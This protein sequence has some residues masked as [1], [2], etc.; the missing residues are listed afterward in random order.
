MLHNTCKILHTGN[1]DKMKSHPATKQ[2]TI[3]IAFNTDGILPF[4]SSSLTVWPLFVSLLNLP[5]RIRAYKQNIVTFILW[6]GK[7]KPSMTLLLN[8]F[9]D[10]LDKINT[11]GHSVK[12]SVG[13]KTF[14]FKPLYG[15][16]DWLLRPQYSI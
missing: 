8:N 9:N 15:I 12:T 10:M 6:I 5:P 7:R 4:K 3:E 11:P 14:H 2:G 1:W 16:F 13:V